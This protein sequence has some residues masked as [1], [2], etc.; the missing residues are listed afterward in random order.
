MRQ[1]VFDTWVLIYLLLFDALGMRNTL[2]GALMSNAWYTFRPTVKPVSVDKVIFHQCVQIST[3]DLFLH[4]FKQFVHRQSIYTLQ[5]CTQINKLP[6][7]SIS[8]WLPNVGFLFY[9]PP[10][11]LHYG[12]KVSVLC[13]SK[14]WCQKWILRLN[15]F[16]STTIATPGVY[17]ARLRG[18]VKRDLIS[19][20]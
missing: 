1:C 18:S 10:C 13:I 5:I 7:G 17:T 8:K 20:S 6:P 15:N 14:S 11:T 4:L 12:S 2:F 16:L 3:A 19:L 9:G